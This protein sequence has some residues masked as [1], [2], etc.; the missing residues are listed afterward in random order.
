MPAVSSSK[1]DK[2]ENS[3]GV[4][5]KEGRDQIRSQRKERTME[6]GKKQHDNS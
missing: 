2:Q 1:E 4:V 3:L 6:K 5:A